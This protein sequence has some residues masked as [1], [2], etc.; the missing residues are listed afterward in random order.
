MLVGNECGEFG[1][2]AVN[3]LHEQDVVGIELECVATIFS[4]AGFKI[5]GGHFHLFTSNEAGDVGIE[6]LKV[7]GIEALVV[8]V[9]IFIARGA[10]AVNKVVVERNH[11]G[12]DVV[13]HELNGKSLRRGG[14]AT[15]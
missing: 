10:G 12:L 8:V 14:F 9:A 4:H 1:I 3:P 2:E 5:I 13:G 15:R 6:L 11:F 7:E